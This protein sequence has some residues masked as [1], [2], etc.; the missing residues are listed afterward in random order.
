MI[1][2]SVAGDC[3]TSCYARLLGNSRKKF[4]FFMVDDLHDGVPIG[5]LPK[6][7]VLSSVNLRIVSWG[8]GAGVQG[9]RGA[10]VQGCRGA[11]VQGCRGA[12]VQ[13]C[14]GAGVQESGGAGERGSGGERGLRFLLPSGST[15]SERSGDS[16]ETCVSVYLTLSPCDVSARA[17]PMSSHQDWVS[18][19]ARG[20][21]DY[22]QT[23][24]IHDHLGFRAVGSG[25]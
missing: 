24:V 16:L 25:L 14:R 7:P 18:C 9:C 23:G 10:G 5:T 3:L 19:P 22:G 13:G 20:R 15:P 17:L 11:G 8:R 2:N 1:W 6:A 12:G 4:W 21:W